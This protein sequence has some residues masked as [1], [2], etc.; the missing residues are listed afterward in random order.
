MAKSVNKSGGRNTAAKQ[1][2]G[3][4]KSASK[5]PTKSGSKAPTK[6]PTKTT[7]K[8]SAKSTPTAGGKGQA[9]TTPK[10]PAKSAQ[11]APVAAE[12]EVRGTKTSRPSKAPPAKPEKNGKSAM[13][14]KDEKTAAPA[15]PNPAPSPDGKA[16]GKASAAKATKASKTP[17]APKAQAKGEAG[18][19]KN[20]LKARFAQLSSATHEISGLKRSLQKT[21]F[22]VGLILQRI[23]NERLYEVKGYGSFESFVEREI[24][25]NKA[26]C[27]KTTRIVEVLP[28]EE[29]LAAGLE[30][31]AAAVAALDGE[32]QPTPGH[33]P[34]GS[35]GGLVPLHKL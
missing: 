14:S 6:A 7:S 30:R 9:K 11:S 35:P 32:S 4:G 31:S 19:S 5:S 15:E 25:I 18:E 8:A 12:G 26:V 34:A 17:K 22:D 2:K 27:M 10:R 28:R 24:D 3:S 29:A 33:R 20:Q 23:Q 1:E 16:S 21:F 13:P